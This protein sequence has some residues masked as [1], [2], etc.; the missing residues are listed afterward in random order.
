MDFRKVTKVYQE[1]NVST[2][3]VIDYVLLCLNEVLRN[4]ESYE[5]SDSIEERKEALAKAQTLLFELMATVDHKTAE[6]E[7]LQVYYAYLNQCL[8][9]IRIHDTPGM[10]EQV[11]RQIKK[12][13][14][15]WEIA[16][17]ETRRQKYTTQWI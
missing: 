6:G 15:S 16:K 13:I 11:S 3:P 17:A 9:E 8:I 2:L 4:V 1:T 12:L 5:E 14:D 10:R 7:R